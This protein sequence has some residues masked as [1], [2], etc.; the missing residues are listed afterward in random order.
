VYLLRE[1]AKVSKEVKDRKM[2]KLSKRLGA[3]EEKDDGNM[4]APGA[5]Q[6]FKKGNDGR[7]VQ[8][9]ASGAGKMQ[10]DSSGPK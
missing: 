3:E 10:I 6:K 2:F 1:S 9:I 4:L 7:P 8:Q 5:G